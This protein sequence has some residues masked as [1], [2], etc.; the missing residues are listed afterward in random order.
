MSLSKLDA[1]IVVNK[2]EWWFITILLLLVAAAAI[3]TYSLSNQRFWVTLGIIAAIAIFGL[4]LSNAVYVN[5]GLPVTVALLLVPIV[6][7]LY[8]KYA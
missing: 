2:D 6:F 7:Y 1:W 5:I 4:L 3:T 8:R